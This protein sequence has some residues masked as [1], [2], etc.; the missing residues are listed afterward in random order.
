MVDGASHPSGL[1]TSGCIC[2]AASYG[3]CAIPVHTLVGEQFCAVVSS[4]NCGSLGSPLPSQISL[5]T[6]IGE[7]P[8]TDFA[9]TDIRGSSRSGGCEFEDP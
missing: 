5:I 3:R 9:S 8:S 1:L 6:F 2:E 7:D 4:C